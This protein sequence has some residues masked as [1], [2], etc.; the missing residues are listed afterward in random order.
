METLTL[1]SG[2]TLKLTGTEF[3]HGKTEIGMRENGIFALSMGKG[4][5]FLRMGTFTLANTN[6]ESL[7]E[8]ELIN[9]KTEVSTPVLLKMA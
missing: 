6:M 3:T 9:G 5:I 8:K 4:L 2:I 1:E 7:R